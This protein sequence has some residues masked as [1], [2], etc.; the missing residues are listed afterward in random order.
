MHPESYGKFVSVYCVYGLD[1]IVCLNDGEFVS[2]PELCH[3]FF[4]LVLLMGKFC[5][6]LSVK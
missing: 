5:E 1:R 3:N 6:D 4:H 2:S